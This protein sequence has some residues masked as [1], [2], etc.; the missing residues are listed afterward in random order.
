MGY[1]QQSRFVEQLYLSEQ[2]PDDRGFLALVLPERVVG[3]PKQ[4]ELDEA[5][6]NIRLCGSFVLSAKMPQIGSEQEAKGFVQDIY[7]VIQ[8]RNFARGILWLTD[9]SNITLETVPLMGLSMDGTGIR[10]IGL[11]APITP[12]LSLEVETEMKVSLD[13]TVLK[14]K[15]V[16]GPQIRFS[17]DA[18]PEASTVTSGT[19]PF[20]GPQ[21]GC[22]QFDIFLQRQS[23]NDKLNWG[24]QFLITLDGQEGHVISEWLPLASGTEPDSSDMIGFQVN[25][26][27]SDVLNAVFDPCDPAKFSCNVLKSYESRRTFL[28]FTGQNQDGTDTILK[29]FYRTTFG[30]HLGILPVPASEIASQDLLP[31]RFVFSLGDFTSGRPDYFQI[32]PEGDFVIDGGGTDE[33]YHLMCGL[34]GTE[35]L[36]IKPKTSS[37]DGDRLRFL[38]RQPAYAP[39]FPF[40][41]ASPLG[42][43][44]DPDAKLLNRSYMTSWATVRC[45]STQ[46]NIHYMAQPKGSSLFGHDQLIYNKDK[47]PDLLGHMTPG[48]ILPQIYDL[49]F[50]L[51]PYAGVRPGD[52]QTSFSK[53]QIEDL[54]RQVVGPTRRGTIGHATTVLSPS[55]QASLSGRI[56]TSETQN[57]TTPSGLIATVSSSE[58]SGCRWNKILLGQNKHPELRQMYFADPN[59]KLVQAFQTNQL[60]L[61]VANAENLG[62]LIGDGTGTDQA[63]FNLMNIEDWILEANV[64]QTNTYNDYNNVIIIKGRK[65]KLYDP[66]GMSEENLV[67]NPEKWTQRADFASPITVNNPAPDP[68]QQVILAQWLQEFFKNASEQIDTEYFETFNEIA[69]DENW[70]GILVLKMKIHK[71]PD[72]LAGIT[73]GITQPEAFNAHHFA[74]KISQVQNNDE[75]VELKDSSSMYGLIYYVDP[76]YDPSQPGQ[77]V[78]P[79]AG[80]TYDFRLLTLKVL[81][82]NTA[83][84]N[85]QSYAQTTLNQF[86]DMPVDRMGEGGN[87]YNTIVLRGSYQNNNGQ[88]VYSLGSITDNTFYFDS[89][90]I[91]KIEVTNAQMST[92]NPGNQPTKPTVISWFGLN[93]FIDYK[94]VESEQGGFDV[95]SFGNDEGQ[96]ELRKGLSFSNLGLQMS[97]PKDDPEQRELAFVSDEIHFDLATST[98]RDGSLFLNFALDLQGLHSGQADSPPSKE[99]YLTVITDARLTGVD[100]GKWYGLRYRLNMGTPGDLAGKVNLTSHLLTAWAPDSSGNGSYKAL[101][102]LELPGTGGG[103][104]LISLQTVLKLSIGQ[105]RLAYDKNKQSFLLMLT[106]IAL[107]F[108]GLLKI[109]PGG[110][111][112]FYLFGN[113]KSEGKPSGLG[114]YAMYHQKKDS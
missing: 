54:E 44:V 56:E 11:E 61:V 86:F 20:T 18:K 85:F 9:P 65:G 4:I 38:S 29:S 1:F 99:G 102:G 113:P 88:P 87:P 89:N 24:F 36:G 59:A 66:E 12:T 79:A 82:E 81:F 37:Y 83:I 27:P 63:F 55:V 73:A 30:A 71:I 8:M 45:G 32:A 100:G 67:A 64:G 28:T 49:T 14:F 19:M 68:S 5:L 16:G 10:G 101:V 70:T 17:G 35:F 46:S 57:I 104:K 75:G 114:W 53:D 97:F 90:I 48:S 52:G 98:P 51:L 58:Q 109:P 108:L 13:G 95:F 78:P 72:D 26:D 91:N 33:T 3:P 6:K 22:I 84:K 43:P 42:P 7:N 103:A 112:L 40:K 94:I 31:S 107:K 96:N 39:S 47:R 69:V 77:P 105:L 80:V 34:Q 92:R 110:S 93:G 74:I 41:V 15:G 21:R 62:T 50:P 106:E 76:D 60:F 23:L 25:I 111:S 2:S